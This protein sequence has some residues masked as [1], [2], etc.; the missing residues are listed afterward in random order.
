MAWSVGGSRLVVVM[1]LQTD[2]G[3]SRPSG[4]LSSMGMLRLVGLLG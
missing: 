2:W 1:A 4:M 3:D